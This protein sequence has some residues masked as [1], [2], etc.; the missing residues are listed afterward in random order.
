MTAALTFEQQITSQGFKHVV[1]IDE[2]G[3][4][5]WAGPVVVGVVCLPLERPDLPAVLHGVRDSKNMTR[6]QREAVLD[7]I[8]TTALAWGVGSADSRIIDQ[9]GIVGAV[10]VAIQTALASMQQSFSGFAPDYL[11]CDPMKLPDSAQHYPHRSITRGDAESLSIAAASVLAKT[12]RD[13]LMLDYDRQY[14]QYGFA[15]HKGYGTQRHRA[16]LEAFG[17]CPIHRMS[18]KPVIATQRRLSGF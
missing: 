18:F 17:A 5:P 15:A 7:R 8:K 6:L 14:P 4:G 13:A 16:A 10:Q 11:L 1:G 9:N 2:A 12:Y 3:R